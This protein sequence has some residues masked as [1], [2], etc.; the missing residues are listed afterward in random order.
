MNPHSVALGGV[1][2]HEH[3]QVSRQADSYPT[4]LWR[5][6]LNKPEGGASEKASRLVGPASGI[7]TTDSDAPEV[8]PESGG[9]VREELVREVGGRNNPG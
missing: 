2:S 7:Q 1:V 8:T 4:R 6:S 9:G 3:S 5:E